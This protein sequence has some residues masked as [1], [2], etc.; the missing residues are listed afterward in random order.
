MLQY[1]HWSEGYNF[2]MVNLDMLQESNIQNSE[3]IR[4]FQEQSPSINMLS[5][6]IS[7][8]ENRTQ[9][10]ERNPSN[11][12]PSCAALPPTS[13]S[14]YYWVWASNGSAVRVYSCDMTRSCGGVTGGWIRVAQVDM[15]NSSNHCPNGLTQR[16]DSGKRTC[17]PNADNCSS[18]DFTVATIEYSKVCGKIIGYQVGAPDSFKTRFR[19]NPTIESNY[20]DGVSLT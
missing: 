19:T 11:S 17:A 3:F 15:R 1:N 9:Y 10:L 12:V 5:Q 4:R 16:S 20:V 8:L 14:D 13:P 7:S 6:H 18:V 2:L